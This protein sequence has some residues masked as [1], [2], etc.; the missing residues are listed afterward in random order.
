MNEYDIYRTIEEACNSYLERVYG[1]FSG[2]SE[3]TT[4]QLQA[5]RGEV[6]ATKRLQNTLRRDLGYDPSSL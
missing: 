1:N 3:Q 6:Q 5:M 2:S 4:E